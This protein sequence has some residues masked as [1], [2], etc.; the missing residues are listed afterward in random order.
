MNSNRYDF[1]SNV[2]RKLAS[3]YI[4]VKKDFKKGFSYLG[5]YLQ[6][7]LSDKFSLPQR[8]LNDLVILLID[9]EVEVG[10]NN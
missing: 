5:K 1:H 10:E 3:I 7:I 2:L 6:L 4:Q 8:K 9:Y